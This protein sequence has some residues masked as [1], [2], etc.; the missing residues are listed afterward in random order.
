[1]AADVITSS[2]GTNSPSVTDV[3]TDKPTGLA[4][5]DLLLVCVSANGAA[6]NPAIDTATGWTIIDSMRTSDTSASKAMWKTADSSDVAASTFTFTVP[7]TCNVIT[8]QLLRIA[9]HNAS[10]PITGANGA[11]GSSS[12]PTFSGVTPIVSSSLLILCGSATAATGI[13]FSGYAVATNNPTWTERYDGEGTDALRSFMA[14]AVRTEI[15][16]TGNGT[17]TIDNGS[18]TW[19]GFLICVGAANPSLTAGFSVATSIPTPTVPLA[20]S[21][22]PPSLSIAAT[23]QVP[24][25]AT[26]VPKWS[27]LAKNSATATNTAK[28]SA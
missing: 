17:L 1:M 21:T 27:D 6:A 20:I 26:A 23:E 25:V 4:V 5:G 16:A 10:S 2:T 12:I 22:T 7:Q 28:N 11:T 13:T 3:T 14:T 9:G 15:S 19:R 18:T 24:A 8:A